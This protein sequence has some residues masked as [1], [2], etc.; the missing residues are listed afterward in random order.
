[1]HASFI[2]ATTTADED[3]MTELEVGSTDRGLERKTCFEIFCCS[4]VNIFFCIS[5]CSCG[6]RAPCNKATPRRFYDSEF[7]EPHVCC[8]SL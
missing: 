4:E 7:W 3:M 1:M 6:R 8:A 2:S 5:F